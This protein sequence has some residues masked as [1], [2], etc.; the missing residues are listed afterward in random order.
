MGTA[1]A[2][3]F[4]SL[5]FSNG[6]R[7]GGEQFEGRVKKHTNTSNHE[8][9]GESWSFF[10]VRYMFFLHPDFL[11]SSQEKMIHFANF[12]FEVSIRFTAIK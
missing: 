7:L 12:K 8:D 6:A 3:D 4:I 5:A 2:D 11:N 9:G 1:E 10:F